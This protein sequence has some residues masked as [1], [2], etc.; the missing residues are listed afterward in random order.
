MDCEKHNC[1]LF[2]ERIEE[3]KFFFLLFLKKK[4]VFKQKCD[5]LKGNIF[6]VKK[7]YSW[8]KNSILLI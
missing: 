1:K 7:N 8:I 3:K 4:L 2:L 6:L 5:L